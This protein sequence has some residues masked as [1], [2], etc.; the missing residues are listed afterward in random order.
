MADNA[1]SITIDDA[2]EKI[3]GARKD[4]W[5]ARAMQVGELSEM[6]GAEQE[7]FVTKDNV[8]PKPDW[9]AL[10]ED[11]LPREAAVLIHLIR[12][13]L[14]AKPRPCKT[15]KTNITRPMTQ[16]REDYVR[17]LSIVRDGL[18]M[19]R[20]EHAV[21]GAGTVISG[22]FAQLEALG[23]ITQEERI[24]Q[25]YQ[26]SPKR[27]LSYSVDNTMLQKASQLLKAGWPEKA[28]VW[29][30]GVRCAHIAGQYHLLK[31]NKTVGGRFDSEAEAWDW[32]KANAPASA[33]TKTKADGQVVPERPHLERLERRGPDYRGGEDISPGDFLKTFGFR[34]IEFGN[35]MPNDERQSALNM[36]YDALCDLADVLNVPAQS[37]GLNGF[38]AVAFGARG[39]GRAA[40]HYESGRKVVNL[41][42]LSGAGAVAHE[43]GHAQ[44][45]WSGNVGRDDW[46]LQGTMFASG[47]RT[48]L[49]GLTARLDNLS[50]YSAEIW[51]TLIE[52]LYYRKTTVDEAVADIEANIAKAQKH[53]ASFD[54]RLGQL[55][56]EPER[57]KTAIRI[58]EAG[59][60]EQIDYID[61]QQAR[62]DA[63]R[64]GAI[65]NLGRK[66]TSYF[67]EAQKLC[68]KSGEY[69]IRPTEMFARAF[70]AWVFDKLAEQGR[71]SDYLVQGV[72]GDRFD[73][74]QFKGNPYPK[75]QERETFNRLFTELA[76]AMRPRMVE[77]IEATPP[78]DELYSATRV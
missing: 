52:T 3:G 74:P 73:D 10:I 5:K 50:G 45:H 53:V 51:D 18:M 49:R 63:I 58:S 12:N 24:H 19:C 7:Q 35:W 78:I 64:D 39:S 37:I 36:G 8:W 21:L 55:K 42:R 9:K 11:G 75:G 76:E 15:V 17:G 38:M 68:G 72:E 61:R 71:R 14:P 59:R 29:R 25:Q 54:N 47:Y 46:D 28:P 16:V 32:L 40:A 69:W 30:K 13:N 77:G 1:S 20:S 48:K 26:L 22:D 34:G 2:G 27:S 56:E 31:G 41:T 62:V 6:T 66:P 44:D 65:T 43:W 60:Q 4:R 57:H 70:E 33:T 67:T 23:E